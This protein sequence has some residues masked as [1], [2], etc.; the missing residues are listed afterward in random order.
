[1]KREITFDRFIRWV[2]MALMLIGLLV[3]LNVLSSVLLPFFVACIAAYMLNPLVEFMQYRLRL[4]SRVL[5][6]LITFILLIG[7]IVGITALYIPP[8]MAELELV[9]QLAERYL[10]SG[11]TNSTIPEAVQHFVQRNVDPKVLKSVFADAKWHEWVQQGVNGL[12]QVVSQ[13]AS[14]VIGLLASLITLIY[15]FFILLD[16]DAMSRNWLRMVPKKYRKFAATLGEDVVDGMNGYFRGQ[17][18]VALLVGVLLA[19]GFSIIGLPLAVPLGLFIGLLNIVP[20]MQ[21]LGFVPT[22]L[23]ALLKA[24]DTG[25]NFWMI[26]GLCVVVFAV[27]QMIQDV[28]LVPR[29]MGHVMGLSPTVILLSLSIWGVLLGFVGLIIALPLT[30]LLIA[31]YKRYIVP[32]ELAVKKDVLSSV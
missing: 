24:A 12:W 26:L 21:M 30:T 19:I 15:L 23:L 28:V 17:A 9:R 16:Y 25:E 5:C 2:G 8:I 3:L 13:T 11:T 1:M 22:V 7:V 4:R 29:I 6:V 10:Y 32:E 18:L 31:Y 20:Y 14:W 27:V